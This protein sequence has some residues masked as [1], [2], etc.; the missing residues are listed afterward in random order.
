M[1]CLIGSERCRRSCRS[2]CRKNQTS[3]M[4]TS[5]VIQSS[6]AKARTALIYAEGPNQPLSTQLKRNSYN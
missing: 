3:G 5:V 2:T 4:P 6:Q 1:V